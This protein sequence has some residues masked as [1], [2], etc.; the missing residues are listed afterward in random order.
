M[1]WKGNPAAWKA[2]A[3]ATSACV[4]NSPWLSASGRAL[5][6]ESWVAAS[7]IRSR[8]TSTLAACHVMA[9]EQAS[10]FGQRQVQAPRTGVCVHGAGQD[11]VG[12]RQPA[13]HPQH[14]RE[15]ECGRFQP[16]DMLERLVGRLRTLATLAG[17]P[18]GHAQV[19]PG[20]DMAGIQLQGM[21]RVLARRRGILQRDRQGGQVG[22]A[23]GMHQAGR[24]P[25]AITTHGRGRVAR[26]GRADR[27][28]HTV[29]VQLRGFRNP[30]LQ[31][32]TRHGS[33][34]ADATGYRIPAASRC[35]R[36]F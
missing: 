14:Q 8:A 11:I 25:V 20:I 29:R 18:A 35:Q 2:S 21:H 27:L 28:K 3:V 33:S 23:V 10:G 5:A 34:C 26:L 31:L 12:L 36:R 9:F 32:Q 16:G 15:I 4:T 24:D 6:T 17:M 30:D 22:P 1:R 13:H 7:G 19:H